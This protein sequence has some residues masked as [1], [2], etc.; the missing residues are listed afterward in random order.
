MS[1]TQSNHDNSV[2]WKKPPRISLVMFL[3]LMVMWVFLW[4]EVSVGN[5]VSGVLVIGLLTLAVPLPLPPVSEMELNISGL[6]R[7]FGSWAI[8][9]LVASVEVAWIAI[10][11]ANPPPAAIIEVP[12]RVRGDITL[13]TAMALINLQ[14]GG[15]IVDVDKRKKTLT[16]H[17]LDASSTCKV[18]KQIAQLTRL[19]RRVLR[20][21][22]NRDVADVE[23]PNASAAPAE[24]KEGHAQ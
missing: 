6:I 16:M 4:G 23:A 13:A 24:A 17:I 3:L 22:E 10:R 14:P 15:I 5:I 18:D 19:E 20:A 12:M 8:D 2:S 9:F 21:F 11:R 7:L 1:K